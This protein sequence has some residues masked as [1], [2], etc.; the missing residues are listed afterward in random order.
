MHARSTASRRQPVSAHHNHEL[1]S[2][3]EDMD[4][5]CLT[6]HCCKGI[7]VAAIEAKVASGEMESSRAYELML[8]VAKVAGALALGYAAIWLMINAAAL[9][10]VGLHCAVWRD[11]AGRCIWL[12]HADRQIFLI[13]I[14]F[15]KLV[16]SGEDII[17]T[18][19]Y[20]LEMASKAI[21]QI[22]CEKVAP[23]LVSSFERIKGLWQRAKAMVCQRIVRCRA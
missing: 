19:F 17:E 14:G 9:S 5:R 15:D 8:V 16:E 22:A 23:A 6:L 12:C 1:E 13:G 18:T 2:I 21:V 3:P 11:R 20:S 4:E 10:R 7:D